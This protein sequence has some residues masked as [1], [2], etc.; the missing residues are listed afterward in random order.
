M[1][2]SL[3]FGCLDIGRQSVLWQIVIYNYLYQSWRKF[4]FGWQ[5]M[6]II[7]CLLW[8]LAGKVRIQQSF[9]KIETIDKYRDDFSFH[10]RGFLDSGFNQF[11]SDVWILDVRA[12]SDKSSYTIICI[13]AGGSSF[14]RHSSA[15][16][17]FHVT[18]VLHTRPIHIIYHQLVKLPCRSTS[19]RNY[20]VSIT[21]SPVFT[22]QLA[23]HPQWFQPVQ[24]VF[25]S[26]LVPPHPRSPWNV[27][28]VPIDSGRAASWVHPPVPS[29]LLLSSPLWDNNTNLKYIT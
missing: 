20:T 16:H 26:V 14:F 29:S 11:V 6:E 23:K 19:Q 18:C 28:T 22:P 2:Q 1:F 27:T 15:T 21:H 4:S 7:K 5:I 24:I 9:D 10:I 3:C 17:K 25:K 12:F 8:R 13:K